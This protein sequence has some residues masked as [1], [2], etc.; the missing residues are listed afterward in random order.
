M[1]KLIR[2]VQTS[3]PV[4]Q[5]SQSIEELGLS[6]LFGR[7]WGDYGAIALLEDEP[8]ALYITIGRHQEPFMDAVMACKRNASVPRKT[9]LNTNQ[10]YPGLADFGDF[11]RVALDV[12]G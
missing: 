3:F 6:K 12:G 5:P 11:F 7:N 9:G 10:D 4:L 1:K 2:T 8:G